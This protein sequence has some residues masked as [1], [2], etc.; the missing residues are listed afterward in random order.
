M[1]TVPVVRWTA[2]GAGVVVAFSAATHGKCATAEH[3]DAAIECRAALRSAHEFRKPMWDAVLKIDAFERPAEFDAALEDLDR[4]TYEVTLS[5]AAFRW[6][7]V[8]LAEQVVSG[9]F[10]ASRKRLLDSL[11]EARE[12]TA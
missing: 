11:A 2:T 3:F 10:A 8:A 7:K 1:S 6:L 12:G 5:P 4:N 9:A